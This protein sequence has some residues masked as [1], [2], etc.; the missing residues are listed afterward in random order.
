MK[1]TPFGHVLREFRHSRGLTVRQLADMVEKTPGYISRIEVRG[2]IPSPDL[3]C[4]LAEELQVPADELIER[5][6][7]DV[8]KR[9]ETELRARYDEA[10][11]AYR[12]SR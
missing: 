1:P 7:R 8:L 10:I 9:T 4:R 11:V 2:E 6:T 5:L 12:K 3:I